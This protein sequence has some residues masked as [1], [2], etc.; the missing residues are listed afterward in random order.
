MTLIP[1][2]QRRIHIVGCS[3][4][5]GTTLMTELMVNGFAID[6]YAEHETSIFHRPVEPFRVFCSKW[7]H[8][9]DVIRPLLAIDRHLWVIFMLRDPRDVVVSRHPQDP[10]VYYTNLGLW[11]RY[12]GIAR[13]LQSHPRFR[14][15]R[16][17]DLVNEPDEVQVRLARWLCFLEVRASFSDYHRSARPSGRSDLALRGV[18]PIDARSV[19]RWRQHKPRIAAQ[20]RLH[21]SITDELLE[22]KYERDDAWLAELAGVE[23]D[24]FESKYPDHRS[25]MSRVR[26]SFRRYKNVLKYALGRSR[27]IR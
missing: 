18:R 8:D 23:A 9:I 19:G 10:G 3:P 27:R 13:R 1:A 20:L 17:E 25:R 24:H 26:R 6:G 2:V 22:M 11:K 12:A 15:V 21:G 14:I 7:P 4:R 16:Y 5:S